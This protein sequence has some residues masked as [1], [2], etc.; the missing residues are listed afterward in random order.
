MTIKSDDTDNTP[1]SKFCH[2]WTFQS[3]QTSFPSDV[4]LATLL[5]CSMKFILGIVYSLGHIC[6]KASFGDLIRVSQLASDSVRSI[7]NR[8]TP[9]L[10]TLQGRNRSNLQNVVYNK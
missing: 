3:S 7:R 4:D 5:F 9:T 2:S 1:H 6:Y 8:Q 10:S